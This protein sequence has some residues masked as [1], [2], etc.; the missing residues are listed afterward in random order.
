M[1]KMTLMKMY[2]TFVFSFIQGAGTIWRVNLLYNCIQNCSNIDPMNIRLH[3][4]LTLP[5]F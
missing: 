3:L 2:I 4:V 5:L 1:K